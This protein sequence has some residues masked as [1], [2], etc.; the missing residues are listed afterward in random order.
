LRLIRRYPIAASWYAS[1]TLVTLLLW[2]ATGGH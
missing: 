2:V 1:G